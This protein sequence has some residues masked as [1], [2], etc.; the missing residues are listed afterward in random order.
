MG[1]G[2]AGSV[3]ELLL[4]CDTPAAPLRFELLDLKGACGEFRGQCGSCL[5][6]GREVKA[7]FLFCICFSAGEW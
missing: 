1:R 6:A 5:V 3:D 2:G 4:F 7:F